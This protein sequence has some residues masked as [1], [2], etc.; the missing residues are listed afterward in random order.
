[1]TIHQLSLPM[2]QA[3]AAVDEEGGIEGYASLFNVEDT[4]S[5][6]VMP[7]AFTKTL[8]EGSPWGSVKML[9]QHNREAPIGLWP[10]L[11]E[12]S[13]GLKSGG[14]IDLELNDGKQSHIRVKNKLIDGLSIG[15]QIIR[16]EWDRELQVRRLHEVQL[17]EI[18]LV[19][20]AMLPSARIDKVKSGLATERDY[21]ELLVR[22]V[23]LTQRE[24]KTVISHGF[25]T[26]MAKK[27]DVEA[28]GPSD[29]STELEDVFNA[30]TMKKG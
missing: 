19:T 15:Y 5:D 1:M 7:G 27:R 3:K 23:G 28:Y 14:K 17:V 8:R 26:M 6:I 20:F 9:Y 12:D 21:E 25:K 4:G 13:L 11:S 22:E 30:F 10:E 18:S 29:T 2:T 24:A 16:D